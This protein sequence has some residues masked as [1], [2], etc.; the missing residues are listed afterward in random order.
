MEGIHHDKRLGGDFA[1]RDKGGGFCR[2][3]RGLALFVAFAFQHVSLGVLF[4]AKVAQAV[5]LVVET[6]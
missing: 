6:L 3:V 1:V 4:F 5:V 2:E